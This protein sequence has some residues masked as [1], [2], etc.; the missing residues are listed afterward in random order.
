MITDSYIT[1]Q[2]A[3]KM[4]KNKDIIN[5]MI[6]DIIN[7]NYKVLIFDKKLRILFSYNFL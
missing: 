4:K 5:P 7:Q 1:K 6:K 2:I 3:K